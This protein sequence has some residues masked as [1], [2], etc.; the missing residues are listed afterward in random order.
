MTKYLFIEQMKHSLHGASIV[1]LAIT[2]CMLL[3]GLSLSAQESEVEVTG[4]ITDEA[5]GKP[6][7]GAQIKVADAAY[8]AFADETGS[9]KITIPSTQLV[10][11]ITMPDYAPREVPLRGRSSVNIQLYRNQF[12][13]GYENVNTLSG[14]ERKALTT[15][16]VVQS[17]DFSSST[18]SALELDIQ[19]RLGAN[20]R[21]VT[22]SG[23]PGTGSS[24]F[25]RG[26]N[27]LN[28]KAQ[29]LIIVDG[30]IWDN[31]LDNTSIH[32]GFFS[33]PLANIDPKDVETIT[34]LKDG[35]S[36]YG[37]K[38][39]NGV[40]LINTARG[41]DMTTRIIANASWGTNT[42]PKL[43][44]MM[45]ASQYKLYASN[46]VQYYMEQY[47]ISDNRLLTIFPFMEPRPAKDLNNNT[48]WSDVVYQDGLIQNY[49]IS[50]NGGDEIAL[51]N[52]SLGYSSMEGTVKNTGME[53]LNARFNSDIQLF[54]RLFSKI[55]VAISR[56]DRDIRNQGVD[57]ISSPEFT[58]LAKEPIL[59]PYGY[60]VNGQ[61]SP[62]LAKYEFSV[63]PKNQ[64]SN[65][66]ALVEKSIGTAYRTS[67]RFKIHPYWQ[68]RNNLTVGS[69]FNYGF[70]KIK[71]EFFIPN[72][73][74]APWII[75]GTTTIAENE[76]RDYTQRQISIFNDSY[77]DWKLNF[78]DHHLALLGGFR[79]MSDEYESD[80][81]RGY[82]TRSNNIKVLNS[83]VTQ[84]SIAGVNDEWR[85]M[86]WYANA[87][88]DY[89]K[90]YFLTLTASADASSRFGKKVKDGLSLAG[91]TWGIFPSVAGAWLISSEDFMQ[92]VS[93]VD[94]LKL[95]ASFGLTGND[96]IDS[97]AGRSYL[98]PVKYT[99]HYIGLVIGNIQNEAIQWETSTK[100]GVGLDTHL[101]NERL[102]LSFDFYNS[103]TRNL[104]TLK[105]LNQIAGLEYY[106]SNGGQLKNQ[107]YEVSADVKAINLR[108]F[109]W[110]LGAGIG[111]YKNKI[112]S[113]PNG[114]YFDT[115]IYGATIRTAV[116]KPAGLF[117]GY[118][119]LGVFATTEEA[120]DARLFKKLDDTSDSYYTAGDVHFYDADGNH[121]INDADK[122]IIGD[123]NPDF[124][125][126]ISNHFQWKRLTMDVLFT[127]SY[128]N[129]VYNY[130]RSILESGAYLFNQTVAV[131]NRWTT[132]GQHTRIPKAVYNDP[133][134]NNVFSDRWVEDGSYL[135]LKNIRLAY[136]I[137]FNFPYLQE[138]TVWAAAENLWTGTKYLGS[139]PESSVNNMVL[140]QGIDAGL[141]P[142]NRSYYL[143]LKINL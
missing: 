143:G 112:V 1:R 58:A 29:P 93:A 141:T 68:I 13:S 117:Y 10:L 89:Q 50:V 81:L 33:D 18:A 100:A 91:L 12:N 5:T 54:P 43:S 44:Q 99:G 24:L 87:A 114:D 49:S 3:S 55:D 96:D 19:A 135:R 69:L 47:K 109:S 62:E 21:A 80:L 39:A 86:S 101:F 59:S 131:T 75:E 133:Q 132:E 40:I 85:S 51:Y 138:I 104:L 72:K 37:S 120:S 57:L 67:F 6:L 20:V 30:V 130:P 84:P 107:G 36:I 134:G 140:G 73:W 118:K 139:D 11:V 76:V 35:N 2:A 79:Y 127:Y 48:N 123:P 7:M 113:L 121:E 122:Q 124:Y 46:Q 63:D 8:S 45:N 137:P 42:V 16:A 38:G 125:G 65:P 82:N 53:R 98:E 119:T 102:G 22:R 94:Y 23:M 66:L 4:T 14:T 41:K 78:S 9:Y 115:N 126:N 116:G 26:F 103:N 52:L 17:S 27:S 31:Q 106:W 60:L 71:E 136:Q 83:G 108:N 32:S 142:L 25:M 15:S 88:Y 128:G 92:N 129:D 28:A 105:E 111:H 74:V 110:S 90:K 77:V 95:R 64:I 70:E 34:I 56:T 61:L 97:N